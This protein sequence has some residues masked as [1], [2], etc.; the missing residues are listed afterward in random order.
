M[1]AKVK[2]DRLEI[3]PILVGKMRI[4]IIGASPMLLNPVG[5]KARRELLYPQGRKTR[6]AKAESLKHDPYEEY[7]ASCYKFRDDDH[8]TRIYHPGS[9]FKKAMADMT[10]DMKEASK[11]SIFRLTWVDEYNVPIYGVPKLSMMVV[12]NADI[13]RTPDIRTRPALFPWACAVT[14]NFA[15]PLLSDGAIGTLLSN[16]G[17]FIGVGDGRQQKGGLDFGRFEVVPPNDP[18]LLKIMKDGGQAQQDAALK[19][20]EFFDDESEDLYSWF[21]EEL[22]GRKKAA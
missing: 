16:A 12:R 6:A 1:A 22:K 19:D 15:E 9:S 7:R 8:P 17:M 2:E 3:R 14:I 21:Y 11:A 13:N 18:R 10:A 5:M 4:G 20:P